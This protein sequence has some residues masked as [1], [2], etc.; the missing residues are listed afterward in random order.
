[1]AGYLVAN[2]D[3][4]NPAG[5]EEY[6]K[7]VGPVVAQYGGRFLVR[8]GEMRLLEGKLPVKRLVVLEFP[9]VAAAQKFYDSAEY[10]PLI[11]LRKANARTDLFL[12][13]DLPG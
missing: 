10:K 11:A 7:K 13:E 1:M 5:F 4:T 9:S 6:R 2:L 12:V 8:G 3:V